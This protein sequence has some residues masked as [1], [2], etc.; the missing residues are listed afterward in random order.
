MWN[1]KRRWKMKV[2]VFVICLG[3]FIGQIFL[4]NNSWAKNEEEVFLDD[5]FWR[6]LYG[7][8]DEKS[9]MEAFLMLKEKEVYNDVLVDFLIPF[10]NDPNW[11]VRDIVVEILGKIGD[12]RAVEPLSKMIDDP[13][14]SVRCKVIEAL[15]KINSPEVV[16]PLISA[17]NNEYGEVVFKAVEA[18]KKIST[19]LAIEPLIKLF[20]EENIDSS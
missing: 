11:Q 16:A 17:L 20:L 19:P 8:Q 5:V 3:V 9:R 18:L 7:P 14:V 6:L 12:A 10:L 15:G 13:S 4:A 2:I 1:K